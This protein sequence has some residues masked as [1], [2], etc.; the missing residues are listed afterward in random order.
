[1][2]QSKPGKHTPARQPDNRRATT[3]AIAVVALAAVIIF[4]TLSYYMGSRR[5]PHVELDR[6]LWPIKGIDI[7]YHNGPIDFGQVANDSV[8]FVFIKASEGATWKDPMFAANFDSARNA[9]LPV[10]AY[11]FFR[12]DVSGLRQAYNLL[13]AL[14]GRVP[15]MPVAIDLEEWAN[16]PGTSTD[17]IIDHLTVMV[18]RL[19]AEG[20]KV[21]IY[22]NKNGFSRFIKRE[23]DGLDLWICSFTDPPISGQ[24]RLWQ[25]SHQGK[26]QGI[27]GPVDLNTFNGNRRQWCQW[28]QFHASTRQ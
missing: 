22:T 11:H 12:F 8:D 6:S 7:S 9:G 14:D 2:T 18:E 23:L 17:A 10:G 28:L 25:H 15:D 5:Q 13:E 1:M 26:I 3:A 4:G 27:S 24:W 19:Q 20:L 21:M 16:A